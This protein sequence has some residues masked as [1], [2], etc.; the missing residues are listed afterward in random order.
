[1]RLWTSGTSIFLRGTLTECIGAVP[2]WRMPS[3]TVVPAGPRIRPVETS[4][5]FPS[6]VLPLTATIR[7]PA[8]MP[9]CFAGEPSNTI[10]TSRPFFVFVES[11]VMPTPS[12]WPLMLCV[13]AFASLGEKYSE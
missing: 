2:W 5:G 6:V 1:M 9:A 13:N 11:I 4:A 12:N 10:R 8:V 3:V 7:S